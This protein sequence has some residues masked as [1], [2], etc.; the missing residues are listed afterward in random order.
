MG[1]CAGLTLVNTGRAFVI[2]NE[3]A[4]LAGDPPSPGFVTPTGKLPEPCKN[5][6]TSV[7][8]KDVAELNVVATGVP[9]NVIVE[10][11]LKF[12]PETWIDVAAAP[13]FADVGEKP[14]T[15]GVGLMMLTV[16]DCVPPPGNGF[17]MSPE[18]LPEFA[19]RAAGMLNVTVLPETLPGTPA[20]VAVVLPMNPVPVT[21]TAV[22]ALPAFIL[23]GETPEIDGAGLGAAVMVK[24]TPP[25]APPPGAGLVTRTGM[26]PGFF[27]A[28][29]GINAVSKFGVLELG[30]TAKPPNTM[31]ELPEKFAPLKARVK[32]VLLV[33]TLVGEMLDNTGT[34]LVTCRLLLPPPPPPPPPTLAVL[35]L[36]PFAHGHGLE[37]PRLN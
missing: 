14:V 35:P 17:E 10:P 28:E 15:V 8:D 7:P 5:D 18:R 22:A 9:P 11:F 24:A 23:E 30:E 1:I 33:P 25:L 20:S 13:A 21:V 37:T 19:I 4:A 3:V 31:V 27:S 34:P 12:V 16:N 2:V 26:A 29:P 6:A 32:P 36:D